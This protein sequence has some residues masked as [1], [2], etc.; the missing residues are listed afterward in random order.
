M[1]EVAAGHIAVD[2][3]PGNA[4]VTGTDPVPDSSANLTLGLL[5]ACPSSDHNRELDPAES[6]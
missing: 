5:P 2:Q 6:Q 4:I 1:I 3:A